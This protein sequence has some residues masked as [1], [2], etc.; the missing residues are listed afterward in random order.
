MCILLVVC[1]AGDVDAVDHKDVFS[2]GWSHVSR[3]LDEQ[4]TIISF[5]SGLCG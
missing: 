4:H 1:L 2:L 5:G 3:L